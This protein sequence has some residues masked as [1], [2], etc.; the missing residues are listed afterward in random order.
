MPGVGTG[1]RFITE[2]V[3][4]YPEDPT[5]AQYAAG[6]KYHQRTY[7]VEWG[8]LPFDETSEKL[9]D[10]TITVWLEPALY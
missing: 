8:R 5:P 9:G 2:P 3:A 4:F 7:N 6:G 10:G 1:Y